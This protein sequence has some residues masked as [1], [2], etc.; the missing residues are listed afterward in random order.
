MTPRGTLLPGVRADSYLST[1]MA[2][3]EIDSLANELE[4]Q[5]TMFKEF[6]DFF[7]SF[8]RNGGTSELF[9]GFFGEGTFGETFNSD[10]LGK[11]ASLNLNLSVEIYG[12]KT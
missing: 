3:V 2:E 12:I 7:E 6:P 10:I 11:L 5:L 4:K 1:L 9:I 8:S